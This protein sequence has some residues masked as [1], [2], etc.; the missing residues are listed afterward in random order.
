MRKGVHP[1]TIRISDERA[2]SLAGSSS[3]R[4]V[5]HFIACLRDHSYR[6]HYQGVAREIA[7]VIA[8]IVAWLVHG[9]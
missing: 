4:M 1:M 5:L 8:L 7:P 2:L 6:R 3:G 9:R